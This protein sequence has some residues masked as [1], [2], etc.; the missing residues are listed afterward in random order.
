MP[1]LLSLLQTHRDGSG[2]DLAERLDITS[3]TVRRD[4]DCLREHDDQAIALQTG[5]RTGC[6]ITTGQRS[7]DA[8][9]VDCRGLILLCGWVEV[10]QFHAC[11]VGSEMPV[12]LALVAVGLLLP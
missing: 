4:I 9:L 2:E 1:A 6:H 10:A 3:R 11:V 5:I 12:D 7:S 8:A